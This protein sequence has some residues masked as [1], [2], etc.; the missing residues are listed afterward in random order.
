MHCHVYLRCSR[1]QNIWG[2]RWNRILFSRHY[3]LHFL[4]SQ[5][6]T[7]EKISWC[8]S[9]RDYVCLSPFMV[10][11]FGA[12]SYFGYNEPTIEDP[13]KT[14]QTPRQILEQ[15]WYMQP[16]FFFFFNTNWRHAAFWSCI[17]WTVLHIN[18]NMA[19]SFLLNIWVL[20]HFLCDPHCYICRDHHYLVLLRIVP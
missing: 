16:I 11:N 6:T 13:V 14:N 15:A 18:F 20:V 7:M 1:A 19:A 3:L 4:Y 10:R 12:N 17:H 2:T 9:F 8:S 5:C